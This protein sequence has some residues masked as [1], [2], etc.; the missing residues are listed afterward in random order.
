MQSVACCYRMIN[1][2]VSHRTG[3]TPLRKITFQLK[4]NVLPLSLA[5][6]SGT[7]TFMGN[8]IIVH[9]DHQP[10]ETIFKKPLSSSY[11]DYVELDF[12]GGNSLANI[13]IREIVTV[14]VCSPRKPRQADNR[15]WP[16]IRKS[17]ILKVCSRVKLP[18]SNHHH[19]T[20]GETGNRSQQLRLQRIS[21]RIF[22]KRI[23]I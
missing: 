5:W 11:S 12:H 21:W 22:G 23:L 3:W 4:R 8:N 15:Q 9:T 7:S 19:N 14:M 2:S 20:A 13:V 17:R 18:K 10:L 16:S 1:L 6:T